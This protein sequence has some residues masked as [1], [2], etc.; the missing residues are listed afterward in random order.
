[1]FQQNGVNFALCSGEHA[2]SIQE[3][4]NPSS[5]VEKPGKCPLLGTK[6]R[7]ITHTAYKQGWVLAFKSALST[8]SKVLDSVF[9]HLT[10]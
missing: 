10:N 9:K 2:N 4:P 6:F 1:M 5:I 8:F 7:E 3:L